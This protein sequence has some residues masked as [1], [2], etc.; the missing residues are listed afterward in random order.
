MR[1]QQQADK[2][3]AE[4]EQR[5]ALA[6]QMDMHGGFVDDQQPAFFQQPFGGEG[7]PFAE[8][9]ARPRGRG[10]VTRDTFMRM[11]LK[12]AEKMAR[13]HITFSQKRDA[14]A[15]VLRKLGYKDESPQF[16]GI[17]SAFDAKRAPVAPGDMETYSGGAFVTPQHAREQGNLDRTF[18]LNTDRLALS[19]QREDNLNR[20][21]QFVESN[22]ERLSWADKERVDHAEKNLQSVRQRYIAMGA[23]PEGQPDVVEAEQA[24][25][26]LM[27]QIQ[28]RF[29]GVL[30]PPVKTDATGGLNGT[31]GAGSSKPVLKPQADAKPG[32]GFMAGAAQALGSAVGLPGVGAIAAGVLGGGQLPQAGAPG[33]SGAQGRA[34]T[35]KIPLGGTEVELTQE[36]YQQLKIAARQQGIQPSDPRIIEL[37][38]QLFVQREP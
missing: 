38:R 19:R 9:S 29:P 23:S 12:A 13:D 28:D 15:E 26:G 27:K 31:V 37:Y 2:L 36:Q 16:Q 7:V 5:N 3:L 35:M 34:P 30:K 20:H 22:K 33:A 32:G 18:G 8:P 24:Y 11:P 25:E 21:R 4:Q 17:M 1:A 6:E 10:V 14:Q